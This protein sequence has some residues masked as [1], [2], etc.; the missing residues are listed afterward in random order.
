MSILLLYLQYKFYSVLR[1]YDN[2]PF[3]AVVMYFSFS[4]PFSADAEVWLHYT[5]SHVDLGRIAVSLCL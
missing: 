4:I 2:Q 3:A 5:H 1:A